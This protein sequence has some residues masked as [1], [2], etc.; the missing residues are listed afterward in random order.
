MMV[1]PGFLRVT[2]TVLRVI[3]GNEVLTF[4]VL[5]TVKFVGPWPHLSQDVR[6]F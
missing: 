1:C 2:D 4:S 5:C 6:S 3:Y